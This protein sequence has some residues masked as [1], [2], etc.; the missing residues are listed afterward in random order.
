[1]RTVRRTEFRTA[2]TPAASTVHHP[3]GSPAG[4]GLFRVKG[5][6][7]PAYIQNVAHAFRRKGLSESEAIERAVG[8]VKDWASGR[9]PNGGHVHPDVQV[10]AAKAVAEWEAA[11]AAAHA[12]GKRSNPF[13]APPGPGGGE[14]TSGPGD[15]GAKQTASRPAAKT[16][17]KAIPGGK[18]HQAAQDAARQAH[19]HQLL[20]RAKANREKA[21]ALE[22]EIHTLEGQLHQKAHQAA[23]AKKAA[24]KAHQATHISSKARKTAVQKAAAKHHHHTQT[25]THLRKRIADLREQ[26]K[27][28][29]EHAGQLEA[30][31]K[32]LRDLGL[33]AELRGGGW[34]PRPPAAP[35]R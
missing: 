15:S 6:Q 33:E 21:D 9:A 23:A 18:A 2:E 4:P 1:M 34:V 16:Q 22:A 31:A 29:R 17:Q 3:F 7:L 24:A 5:L 35:W 10:A 20:E 28:L 11:K 13:H 26:V 30:Q 8:V 12:S 27:S 32:N 25:A 14:F 19:R